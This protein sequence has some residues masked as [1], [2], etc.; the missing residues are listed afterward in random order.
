MSNEDQRIADLEAAVIALKEE[1]IEL[2]TEISSLSL[3]D[4]NNE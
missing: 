1:I 3:E 2:K 4:L